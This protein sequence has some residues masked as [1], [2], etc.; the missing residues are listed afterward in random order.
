MRAQRE[1]LNKDNFRKTRSVIKKQPIKT[2]DRE[3]S[4][5][6]FTRSK[7]MNKIGHPYGTRLRTL[8]FGR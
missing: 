1:N 6:Y 8:G 7:N 5:P 3:P 2:N 4:H